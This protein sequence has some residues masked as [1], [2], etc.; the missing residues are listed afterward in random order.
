MRYITTT[1]YS[2]TFKGV[3]IP[4]EQL[5]KQL[6]DAEDDIDTMT[7]NRIVGKGFEHLTEFQKECILKAICKQ[8]EYMFVYGDYLNNPIKGYSIG[9]THMN[10][11]SAESFGTKTTVSVIQELEKTGLTC[12]RL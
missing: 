7:L 11:E 3:K 10:F 8:A 1:Y 6:N 12:Q 4:S 5:E 2:E 9:S